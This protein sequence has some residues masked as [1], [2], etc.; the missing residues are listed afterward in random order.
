M[1]AKKK[2]LSKK[3]IKEDKLV[4]TFYNARKFY[5]D[6]QSRVLIVLGGIAAII[7]AIIWYNSKITQDNLSAT[8][9]LS[10]VYSIYD[11]GS[12]QEAIDGKPGTNVTGL[13]S[14]VDNYGGSEQ[15]ETARIY[16]ANCYYFLGDYVNAKDEY[17]SYSGSNKQLVSSAYAG[18]AACYEAEED[19]GNAADYYLMA[20]EVYEY[21]PMN[22]DNL[23]N[24]GKNYIKINDRE[25]AE[26]VLNSIKDK[27]SQSSVAR[28]VDRY[29]ALVNIN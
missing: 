27:Y 16:L 22:A 6:N 24:A 5:E 23:L 20:A 12:F 3:Q 17:D 26:E 4:T 15:G 25:K 13:R 9:E 10:R 1:L 14:I 8:V 2:K 18:I 21:N 28:E 19:F 29:L 11:S 7:V